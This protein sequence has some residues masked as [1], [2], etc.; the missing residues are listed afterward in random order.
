MLIL[1]IHKSSHADGHDFISIAFYLL[2]YAVEIL[3]ATGLLKLHAYKPF[4]ACHMQKSLKKLLYY[5]L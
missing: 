5:Y 3:S 1:V 2:C 4:F